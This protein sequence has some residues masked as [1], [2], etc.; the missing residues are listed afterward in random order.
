[1]TKERL[2]IGELSRRTGIAVKTLRFYSDEGLLPPAGRTRGGYRLYGPADLARLDL[3]RTL[4]EAGLP[5]A[6]IRSVVE[7]E[8]GLGDAL[9]LR[10][11]A[12]EAHIVS[13]QH[14]AA[15]LRAALRSEPSD[16]D[17]RRL[18]A[19]T[20]LSNE[21]RKAVIKGFYDQ[22]S[23]GLPVDRGWVNAMVE[24]SA[25]KL[26]DE[27]TPEQ[28]DAWIELSTIVSDPGFVET[29]RA[30]AKQSWQPGFDAAAYRRASDEAAASARA[31]L[32]RGLPPGATEAGDIVG[33]FA[34]AVAA[35]SG[36]PDDA[37]FRAM[38]RERFAKH[39][40]RA[41]RYWELVALLKGQPPQA[42][43][44][45]EWAWLTRAI[46]HHLGP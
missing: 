25:P 18:C 12:V 21:E 23:Q 46:E 1:M 35:A 19:V 41:S 32:D 9:R 37:A 15:A 26:P 8:V 29:M 28:L 3:I 14:V 10:L 4:R 40:P 45:E 39:D 2:T 20:R 24:A 34:G 44:N 27:P 36:Q 5:L 22:V 38:M 11:R 17:L 16:E 30:S 33:R 13:L 6:T 43:P 42:S 31:A 7:R